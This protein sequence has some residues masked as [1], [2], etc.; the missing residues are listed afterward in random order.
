MEYALFRTMPG[1]TDA[2]REIDEAIQIFANRIREIKRKY[3]GV[4]IGDTAT[5][6]AITTDIYQ[7]IHSYRKDEPMRGEEVNNEMPILPEG[8]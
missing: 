7:R 1:S 8:N 3:P 4:G 6:E 2:A 5:D